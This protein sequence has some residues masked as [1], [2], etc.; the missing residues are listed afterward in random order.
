LK[1]LFKIEHKIKN[2]IEILM[3]KIGV[4]VSDK[5]PTTRIVAVTRSRMISKYQRLTNQTRCY[6]VHD[7]RNAS[8][9]GD[10]VRIG[11]TRPLSKT[12]RWRI[13]KVYKKY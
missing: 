13:D 7:E 3:R 12:K 4:V 9:Y 10:K 6:H 2:K 8:H 5:V 11:S 1:E